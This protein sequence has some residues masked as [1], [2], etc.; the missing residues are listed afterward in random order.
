MN[1]LT[2]PKLKKKKKKKKYKIKAYN[3]KLSDKKK[4][5]VRFGQGWILSETLP[6]LH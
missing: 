6:E 4:N 3:F 2:N 5:P 1:K